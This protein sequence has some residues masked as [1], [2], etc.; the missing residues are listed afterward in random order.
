MR[1]TSS[2]SFAEALRHVEAAFAADGA[3]LD[4]EAQEL[5]SVAD[6]IDSSNQLVRALSDPG[7]PAEVKESAVRALLSNRV[8][9]RTLE[10]TLEVVRHRWSEQE[11]ILDA[12]E[13]LGVTALLGQAQSE[14]VLEQV[15]TE[16]FDVS[17]MIDGSGELTAALDGERGDPARRATLLERLL[18]GRMHWLTVAL[19]ARAVGRRSETKP[20][21]RVE[22]FARFASDQRRRA[23]A[24][25]SSAM[26]LSEA[27]QAR[28]G[29]VLATIYG[30]QIQLNLTVDPAVVGGLQIQV[31]DD[32]YDATV[33]AR[34]S[35]AR[36][37]LVA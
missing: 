6:A 21:R 4:A 23:F 33:L 10:T 22:E 31:G 29:A 8:S 18:E 25:V 30:R 32:L 13:L 24:S 27:Q 36:S 34:L 35:R 15:E 17:R 37:Q 5:F 7:R 20:A 28:L 1:G 14:G 26:P 16:L 9:P 3:A 11:D 2:T 19:G 12:L